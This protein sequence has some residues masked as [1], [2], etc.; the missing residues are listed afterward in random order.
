MKKEKNR[1]KINFTNNYSMTIKN[2]K[3]IFIFGLQK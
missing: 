3:N 1:K 2:G